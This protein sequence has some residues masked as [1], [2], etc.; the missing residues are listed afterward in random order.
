MF[1]NSSTADSAYCDRRNS[2]TA[3][4][5]NSLIHRCSYDSYLFFIE[6][7]I[8]MFR[9]SLNQSWIFSEWVIVSIKMWW[10]RMSSFLDRVARIIPLR[11][12]KKMIGV[13]TRRIIAFVQYEF[14]Q[15]NGANPLFVCKTMSFD[16]NSPARNYLP[17]CSIRGRTVPAPTSRPSDDMT[18]VVTK[19]G[20]IP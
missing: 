4:K 18:L 7:S 12:Y 15:R 6:D 17:I 11:A 20:A 1:P 5:N 3:C 9:S 14:A 13:A 16:K 19:N 2:K 8:V 10:R